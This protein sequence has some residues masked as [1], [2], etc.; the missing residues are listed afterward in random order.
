MAI[1]KELQ[2]QIDNFCKQDKEDFEFLINSVINN[3]L[4]EIQ[5]LPLTT[6]KRENK[7]LE[8]ILKSS[9]YP[10]SNIMS[11]LKCANNIFMYKFEF[12]EYSKRQNVIKVLLRDNKR[13]EALI[14]KIKSKLGK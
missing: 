6:Y 4:K 1:K 13:I 8:N 5:S 2:D 3:G 9:I 7:I 14:Y 10:S 12:L 11:L